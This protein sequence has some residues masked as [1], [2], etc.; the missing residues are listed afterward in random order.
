MYC[1]IKDQVRCRR[2]RELSG[3]VGRAESSITLFF[4]TVAIAALKK[5]DVG[6][7]MPAFFRLALTTVAVKSL[8]PNFPHGPLDGVP[9]PA[10]PI[11]RCVAAVYGTGVAYF[12]L[13]FF[14]RGAT[15][16]APL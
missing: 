7:A 14:L 8:S 6:P 2:F 9:A 13:V 15:V 1:G 10:C 3:L 11:P 5:F 16:A 12:R 4:A